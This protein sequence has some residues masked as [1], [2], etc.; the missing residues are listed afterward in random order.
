M[1]MDPVKS[2]RLVRFALTPYRNSE[3]PAGADA[4]NIDAVARPDRA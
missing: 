1:L 2:F 3:H 4:L